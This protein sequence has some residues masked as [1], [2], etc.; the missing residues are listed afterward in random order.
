MRQIE[1][2]RWQKLNGRRMVGL[3]DA[4]EA[5]LTMVEDFTGLKP[6]QYC[7][8][9]MLEKLVRDGFMQHPGAARLNNNKSPKCPRRIIHGIFHG[10]KIRVRG[11]PA[12][13]IPV[14]EIPEPNIPPAAP[15]GEDGAVAV[16]IR[17]E[18]EKVAAADAAEFA[19]LK[20]DRSPATIRS[21]SAP[22][23]GRADGS[24]AGAPTTRE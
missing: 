15:D 13:K 14:E 10:T 21:A 12:T 23:S 18:H 8:Q 4:I 3:T 20:A 11:K 2:N 7:R 5:A 24:A 22:A 17:P 19:L 6:S 1:L 16:D 9:A